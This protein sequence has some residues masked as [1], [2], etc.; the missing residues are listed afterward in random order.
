MKA[1]VRL[2]D[3]QRPGLI[4]LDIE[5]PLSTYDPEPLRRVLFAFRIQVVA[6]EGLVVGTQLKQRLHL[7]EFDGA[8]LGKD[9]SHEIAH[10]LKEELQRGRAPVER[11]RTRTPSGA[12]PAPSS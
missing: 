4:A 8:P 9:R 11:A 10:A 1:E 2:L 3:S 5:R 12:W 7:C 6:T